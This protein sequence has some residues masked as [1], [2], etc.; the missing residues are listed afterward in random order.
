MDA[1]FGRVKLKVHHDPHTLAGVCT[2]GAVCS[3]DRFDNHCSS[4][5]WKQALEGG[6]A[7]GV[8]AV[9]CQLWIEMK[10]ISMKKWEYVRI[11]VID[12]QV[13]DWSS[14]SAF[15]NA[16]IKVNDHFIDVLKIAGEAGWEMT[17]AYPDAKRVYF[18]F[19]RSVP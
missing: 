19:K 1:G 17:A 10:G 6:R 11:T 13:V 15:H 12:W 2:A 8:G 18:W 3:R 5:A 9:F 4:M 16:D 7:T 14:I